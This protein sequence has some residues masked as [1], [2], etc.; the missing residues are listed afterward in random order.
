MWRLVVSELANKSMYQGQR[1]LLMG[2]IKAQVTTIYIN[3]KKVQSALFNNSTKPVFRSESARFILYI[4]MSKE[5]WDFDTDGTGEIMFHKVING[6]LPELFRRWST[7]GVH[8]LISIILFTRLEY[9]PSKSTEPQHQQQGAHDGYTSVHDFAHKDFYRV[10]VSD[11]ASGDWAAILTQLK[12]EFKVFLRD[13]SIRPAGLRDYMSLGQE[14]IAAPSAHPRDVIAGRPTAAIRGNILEAINL[15]SAQ[16]SSDYID[17]DLVRTGLSI[18]IITPGTGV[19]EV[20]YDMLTMTTDKLIE[21]GVGV[22]LVCLSRMPL[23]SVPLFKYKCPQALK[24]ISKHTEGA[25]D[26]EQAP[27]LAKSYDNTSGYNSGSD[28]SISANNCQEQHHTD[29]WNFAIPHW[30]DVSF[31]SALLTLEAEMPISRKEVLRRKSV[32][33]VQKNFMPRIRMY[34]VQ[35]MGITEN[36]MNNIS[37]PLLHPLP[38]IPTHASMT[39][40]GKKVKHLAFGADT[41]LRSTQ[42]LESRL[43]SVYNDSPPILSSRGI[44]ISAETYQPLLQWMYDYDDMLFRQPTQRRSR[45]NYGAKQRLSGLGMIGQRKSE[46]T[47]VSTSSMLSGTT[48]GGQMTKLSYGI[49]IINMRSALQQ[50]NMAK[51]SNGE[52]SFSGQPVSKLKPTNLSRQISFGLR[53]FGGLVPKAIPVT[54]ISSENAHFASLQ[55][56]GLRSNSTV[57]AR[58]DECITEDVNLGSRLGEPVPPQNPLGETASQ[59]I[60]IRTTTGSTRGSANVLPIVASVPRGLIDIQVEQDTPQEIT[61]LL[62]GKAMSPWLT[63]INPSDPQRSSIDSTN[64]LGK[65]HDAYPRPAHASRIRWKSLCSPA[66][67]PLTTEQVPSRDQLVAEYD[68]TQYRVTPCL[69]HDIAEETVPVRWLIREL[70]CARLCQGFQ[71]VVGPRAEHTGSGMLSESVGLFDQDRIGLGSTKIVMSKGTVIHELQVISE[72]VAVKQLTR[73]PV[74]NPNTST[75]CKPIIYQPSVRTTLSNQYVLRPIRIALPCETYDWRRLDTFIAS[76][77][78]DH[79][80]LYPEQLHFWRARFVLIPVEQPSTIKRPTVLDEEDDD[81]EVRLEGIHKLTQLWQRHRYVP[82]NE[83]RFQGL[84]RRR[85]DTNPLDIIYQTRNASAIVAAELSDALLLENEANDGKP[86]QLL[87]DAD[88]FERSNLNLAALARV[89][90]SDRGVRMMDRR[91]HWRLH[92]NCFIGLE[93]TTWLLNNFRDVE[94][95]AEAVELGDELMKEGLFQ[96]VEGRHNFRDGNFFYQIAS[97]HRLPRPESRVN[98]FSTRKPDR[99]VPSTPITD[100]AKGLSDGQRSRSNSITEV[101]ADGH[102]PLASRKNPRVALSK[103]LIYDVDHRKRS[104]RQELIALHYDRISSSDDCYHLRIDWLCVTPKLIEDAIVAWAL[105]AER[106][107]LRLVEL[108]IGE[109]SRIS[110]VHPFRA[111]YSISLVKKPPETKPRDYFDSTS[112]APKAGSDFPYHSSILKKFNF[113]LDLEAVTDF[114]PS[115]DVTYSWGKPD[116]QYPQYISRDGVA[117]AQITDSGDFLLSAN[118]LYNNRSAATRDATWGPSINTQGQNTVSHRSPARGLSL[119]QSS[120]PKASPQASPMMRPIPDV[121]LGYARPEPITPEK[122]ARDLEAFCRDERA[123]D[124]FYVETLAK[125]RGPGSETPIFRSSTPSL[126]FTLT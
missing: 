69:D 94:S 18:V 36:E 49:D 10:L 70:I 38:A 107:G 71:V 96:H 111:P 55:T 89:I 46:N 41:T 72:S 126:E 88:L 83:R 39:D 116:Y 29:K 62:P 104:Y 87:P 22:D 114:P 37:V 98:W 53:G 101:D 58:I 44:D 31:W 34:E 35:M 86:T 103:Q 21:N 102:A 120:S 110:E 63:I 124:Q 16:F 74:T 80:G 50:R 11:L 20:D 5:M 43:S 84:A 30:I 121:G 100:Y 3:G 73:R 47:S 27:K 92:Y 2:T 123:L 8:H 125:F 119:F 15:A 85:K 95:R 7:I 51:Q 81:E 32:V 109:G 25:A 52:S 33:S 54:E 113:V 67:V 59:P 68:E 82:S 6:F 42:E 66:S 61:T 76:H 17:R 79:K 48:I 28:C 105:L 65:C 56:Q 90:Q 40:R 118:R 13:V 117:L 4:Q 12:N 57:S 9:E 75:D 106:F 64:R 122:I 24:G 112:F 45:K 78:E 93:L 1:L 99:S 14:G 115:V 108:P 91:W 77:E 97:G 26:R 60:K 23:H 19:F